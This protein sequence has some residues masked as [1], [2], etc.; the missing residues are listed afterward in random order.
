[1][2]VERES[3]VEREAEAACVPSLSSSGSCYQAG[4]HDDSC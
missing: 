3:E 2:E 1:M 4:K